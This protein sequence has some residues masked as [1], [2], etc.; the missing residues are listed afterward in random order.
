MAYYRSVTE[1]VGKTP[2]VEFTNLAREKGF[3]ATVLSKLEGMIQA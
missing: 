2:M 3:Q 1:L